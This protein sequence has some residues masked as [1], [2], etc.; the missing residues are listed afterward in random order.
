[1]HAWGITLHVQQISNN[2]LRVEEGSLRRCTAWSRKA[3]LPQSGAHRKTTGAPAITGWL[4]K[5]V[6]N[7]PRKK[8][9]GGN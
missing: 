1:M 8:R 9:A 3:G 6:S 7:W 2:V 5:D 4:Q